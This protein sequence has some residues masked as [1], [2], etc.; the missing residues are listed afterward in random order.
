MW[1][2]FLTGI[3]RVGVRSMQQS[4]E[5]TEAEMLRGLLLHLDSK[6]RG[7]TVND[8]VYF[9]IGRQGPV[10]I[11]YLGMQEGEAKVRQWLDILEKLKLVESQRIYNVTQKGAEALAHP[12]EPSKLLAQSKSESKQ[13]QTV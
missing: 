2:L 8:I 13:C 4:P 5:L 11:Q 9:Y 10:A 1:F 12:E 6:G 7:K 3:L